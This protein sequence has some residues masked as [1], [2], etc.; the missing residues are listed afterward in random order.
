MGVFGKRLFEPFF[1]EFP[2][3]AHQGEQRKKQAVGGS[4]LFGYF[5]LAKQEKVS[6]LSV[7]TD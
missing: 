7:E 6:R 1:G 4:L 3:A 2:L 5:F